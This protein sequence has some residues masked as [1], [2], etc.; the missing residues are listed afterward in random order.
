MVMMIQDLAGRLLWRLLRVG[1]V[2]A[3][4]GGKPTPLS[5]GRASSSAMVGMILMIKQWIFDSIQ[6]DVIDACKRKNAVLRGA[7]LE[8]PHGPL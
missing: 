1:M 8:A 6:F 2:V 7:W 5:E 4:V 3:E